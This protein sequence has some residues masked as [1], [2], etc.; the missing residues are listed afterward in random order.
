MTGLHAPLHGCMENG[1]QRREDVPFF[2]DTL[3]Q[4]GYSTL[5]TGKTHFG[6]PKSFDIQ[7]IAKGEKNSDASSVFALEIMKQGYSSLSRHPNPVP[8]K[9]CLESLIVDRTIETLEGLNKTGMPFFA[10]CSLLSPH[11]PHDPPGRWLSDAIFKGNIP[12]PKFS[13]GEWESLPGAL[14]EFC[15]IPNPKQKTLEY[16]HRLD[17]AQGNVADEL[18]MDKMIFDR[19]L[20]Y[21]SCAYMDS[22]VGRLMDFL[23]ASGLRK[24]TLVIFTSD[25]GQQLF[26]HGFNDKHN[27]YDESLRVPFI[28]S[29][30]GVLPE[31][32]TRG[33]ASHVD[34]A[35]SIIAAAGG[36][37]DYANG[38]DL[39]TPLLRGGESPRHF[40]AAALYGSLAVVTERWKCEYYCLDDSIRLFDRLNDPGETRN[41]ADDPEYAGVT[42]YL[43]R[44]L[45]LLR[46]GMTDITALKKSTGP[47]GPVA[48]RVVNRIMKEKGSSNETKL[49]NM[50]RDFAR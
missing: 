46:S 2:T 42:A 4:L 12:P 44:A 47:G 38:F 3:K 25:H 23:D 9:Y 22:L 49:E 50:L 36:S 11:A 1:L 26:D 6:P 19:E 27:Y 30:P 24:N 20:Y 5:M 17:G 35:P 33:F 37:C 31:N 14:K 15:G 34:L 10:F 28:M 7:Y 43:S 16:P 32:Q 45:L 40:A 41:L 18:D 8:E 13:R 21:R 48:M 29:L 39:F